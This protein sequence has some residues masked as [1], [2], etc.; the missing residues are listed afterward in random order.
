MNMEHF[1]TVASHGGVDYPIEGY[2]D[3]RFFAARERF[4]ENFAQGLEIGA[5]VAMVLNGKPVLD[6]WGGFADRA[7][8]RAWE[9]DT[10]VNMMSVSKAIAGICIYMLVDRGLVDPEEPVAR[11][12]PEFAAAGKEE[13]ALKYVLDHRAGLALVTEPLER[14]SVYDAATM[15]AALARQAPLW[16]PGSDAGYHV[17]TQGFILGEIV[18]RVS[19]ASLGAFFQRE[20]AGPLDLDYHIGLKAADLPRCAEWALPP[21]SPLA[22]AIANPRASVEGRF[23]EPLAADEDFNSVAW[24]TAEI[25]SA[26]G[27]GNARAVAKFYG[28]LVSGVQG[29][30]R[31]MSRATLERMITEQHNIKERFLGRHYHQGSG[32]VLSSKPNAWMGPNPR[33]FGHQG[34]GGAIGF[35][36][37]D[38][39]VGFSYAMNKFQD[40]V[41]VPTRARIIEAIYEVLGS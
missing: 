33:A 8:R 19:G 10:I 36:D 39:Q 31:L 28:A 35:G 20:V 15:A 29:G 9:R 41:T 11:Y 1:T 34:A 27:H 18:R 32:V 37:P 16:E 38:A 3:S 40:D 2:C 14:G 22:R 23:W 26:N 21:D 5:C 4:I 13:L 30:A 6:L 25:P 12:W 24:R 17:L 7:C